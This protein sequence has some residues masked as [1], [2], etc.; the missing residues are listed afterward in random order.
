MGRQL[1]LENHCILCL[2]DVT[3]PFRAYH[4]GNSKVIYERQHGSAGFTNL[5]KMCDDC[6]GYV[7][8]GNWPP[9]VYAKLWNKEL[10][11]ERA[12]ESAGL[13]EIAA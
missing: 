7:R 10:V 3:A 8:G 2:K 1:A 6:L 9:D 13:P 5:G 4:A 12:L 11:T